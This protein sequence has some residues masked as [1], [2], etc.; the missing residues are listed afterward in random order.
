MTSSGLPVTICFCKYLI[1]EGAKVPA[2]VENDGGGTY[3]SVGI[4]SA[5]VGTEVLIDGDS[6]CGGPNHNSLLTFSSI[7]NWKTFLILMY[8][9]P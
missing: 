8:S 4:V 1:N 6:T 7:T 9:D 3:D 2:E 5:N